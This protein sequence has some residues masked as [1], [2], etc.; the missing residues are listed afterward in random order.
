MSE[1]STIVLVEDDRDLAQ[2]IVTFLGDE[3]FLVRW[4]D[5]GQDAAEFFAG[6]GD[7]DL[8]V[9]DV[10]L[11][12]LNGVELCQ[13]VRDRH[14]KPI[15]MLTAKTDDLTEI[16]SLRQGADGY[17]SKPVRPHVLLAHIQA[18][19]RR[20]T[21]TS[22][23]GVT[24][25]SIVIQSLEVMPGSLSATLEGQDLALTTA[26]FQ[27]LLLLAQDAGALITREQLYQSLRGFE[28]D[29]LDRAIDMRVSSI[30]K[31]L[32]DDTPPFKYIKTVRGKGYMMSRA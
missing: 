21:H 9:L 22:D 29:G 8:A 27:L 12:N 16:N 28:Y 32:K 17:L 10:M 3:G 2:M 15:L 20:S 13:R 5:D 30:R 31:K 6:T 11:P 26:E 24:T 7:F 4:F 18:L 25:D 14:T 23:A 1:A 19:L